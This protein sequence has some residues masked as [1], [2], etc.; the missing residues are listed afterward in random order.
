MKNLIKILTRRI[1]TSLLI[2]YLIISYIFILVRLAPGDP[3]HKFISPDLKSE[4]VKKVQESFNLDK[5]ILSQYFTFISNSFKGD[6]GYSFNHRIKVENVISEYLPVTLIIALL[7][8]SIQLIASILLSLAAFKSDGGLL[9]KLLS[10]ASVI[11]YAL[12]TFVIGVFLVMIFSVYLNVLP[13]SG[14]QSYNHGDLSFIGKIL[15]YA[16]HL[17]LPLITV[18]LV[19]TAVFYKYLRDNLAT[20]KN[21]QFVLFLKANGYSENKILLKHILPNSILPLISI[22]GI[23]FGILMGGTLLTEVIF[24]IPG[25][26]RLTID[27]IFTNDYPLVI[28]CAFTSALFMIL[29]NLLA[30]IV[31]IIINRNLNIEGALA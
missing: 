7:S 13:A 4:Y 28:G 12:P 17:T 22:A 25:M 24:G 29:A 2:L 1:L 3:T 11:S 18:S 16:A 27:A 8:L 19:G 21:Q 20:V 23:E 6:F 31:K 10:R 5:P 9:D 14:I 15:D 26:G 30:D